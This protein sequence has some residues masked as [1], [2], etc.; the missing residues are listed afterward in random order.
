GQWKASV[1]GWHD[2]GG[3]QSD[4][5]HSRLEWRHCRELRACRRDHNRKSI[6]HSRVTQAFDLAGITNTVGFPFPRV[7]G[8]GRLVS[9]S[10]PV[11]THFIWRM[12]GDEAFPGVQKPL[13]S[14]GFLSFLL[15]SFYV[16]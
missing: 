14:L 1:C 11:V 4:G 15:A 8:E 12:S 10:E 2:P 5:K 16:S 6:K 9:S 13:F 3:L 7:P